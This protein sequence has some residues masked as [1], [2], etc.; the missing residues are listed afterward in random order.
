MQNKIIV[1]L[2]S[3][4]LCLSAC[5]NDNT[6]K[7]G[8]DG[9]SSKNV[10]HSTKQTTETKDE[11]SIE[12]NRVNAEREDENIDFFTRRYGWKTQRL[13]NGLRIEMLNEGVGEKIKTE[14]VVTVE[15]TTLLLT[16]DTVYSSREN[17]PKVFKVDKS[18]EMIGLNE[19][20]KLMRKNGKAHVV[21]PSFLA[22]GVAGD[23]Q[24]IR[25]KASLAMTIEITDVQ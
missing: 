11:S 5:Q 7:G 8:F 20:V 17:G 10:T 9:G 21:I 6:E 25:G 1:S 18:E 16:G 24:K 22:Y 14:N 3:L 15:Y 13:G 23:G 2:A 4:L 12:W 19:A